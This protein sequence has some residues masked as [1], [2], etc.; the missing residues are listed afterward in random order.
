MT[1]IEGKEFSTSLNLKSAKNL[2]LI[3]SNLI[4]ADKY[5]GKLLTR[6]ELSSPDSVHRQLNVGNGPDEFMKVSGIFS[7]PSENEVCIFDNAKRMLFFY[8]LSDNLDISSKTRLKSVSLGNDHMFYS[9]MPFGDDY[10]ASGNFDGNLL[11]WVDS[12]MTVRQVFGLFPGDKTD[13]NAGDFYLKNQILMISDVNF[14]YC[15]AAGIYNDWIAFFK[16]DTDGFVLQKEYFYTD[17]ELLPINESKGDRHFHSIRETE[18][19]RRAY[20]SSFASD[21]FFYALYWGIPS[22]TMSNEDQPCYIYRFTLDGR[23]KDGW[24]VPFLLQSFV[25]DEPESTLYGLTYSQLKEE[26]LLKFNLL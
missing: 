15:M 2:Y 13:V 26:R 21:K 10:V 7:L 19:T 18:K 16:K 24:I 12:S 9:V 6:I 1:V 20:R 4:I 22:K 14:S 25:V 3:G 23:F 17:S 5:D 11:A 8:S